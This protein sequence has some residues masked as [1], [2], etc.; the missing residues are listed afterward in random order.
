MILAMV[1]AL[2]VVGLASQASATVRTVTYQGVID[3]D[4]QS[5]EDIDVADLFGGG[6]LANSAITA[7]FSYN[8]AFGQ[9]TTEPTYAELDGGTDFD[10]KHKTVE[11][12]ITS[13]TFLINGYSYS[14][15]PDYYAYVLTQSG[16]GGGVQEVAESTAED[17]AIVDLS[18]DSAP[19]KLKTTFSSSGSG[20][21]YLATAVQGN[22]NSDIITFD[23]T[24][25]TV[26]VSAAPEPNTWMLM[27]AGVGLIGSAMRYTRKRR[28]STVI[29]GA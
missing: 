4:D 2:A 8:T 24:S 5:G 18:T 22:G 19:A 9:K 16:S 21:G 1:G 12:P 23:T 3:P 13:A 25:V 27:T 15:Y 11:S 20:S 17:D 28:V 10:K 7:V 6:D 14:F 26:T 29:V